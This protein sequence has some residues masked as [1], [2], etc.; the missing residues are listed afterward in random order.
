MLKIT[1]LTASLFLSLAAVAQPT[2]VN[3]RPA[4]AALRM[5]PQR[6]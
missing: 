1:L 6:H 2:V 4:A 3:N 5:P